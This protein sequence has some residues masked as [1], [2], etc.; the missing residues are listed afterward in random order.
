MINNEF[1]EIIK[2]LESKKIDC[3]MFVKKYKSR[4]MTELEQYYDG[5]SWAL[6]YAIN[7][8]KEK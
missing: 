2:K 1:G 5:A 4:K 3:E 6:E 8:I 7:L